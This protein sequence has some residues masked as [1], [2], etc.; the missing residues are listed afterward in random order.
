M[1][2]EP[3]LSTEIWKVAQVVLKLL[4]AIA[5]AVLLLYGLLRWNVI[6]GQ[7][8]FYGLVFI[9]MIIWYGHQSYKWK[10]DSYKRMKEDEARNR[11]WEE[12]RM[13]RE[14]GA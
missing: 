2:E 5:A 11:E 3:R 6:Y 1:I 10:L 7:L 13:R 9:A 4:G 12:A 14:K 8:V